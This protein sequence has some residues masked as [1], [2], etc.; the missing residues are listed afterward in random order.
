MNYNR[1]YG[2]ISIAEEQYWVSGWCEI[3]DTFNIRV[4]LL[5]L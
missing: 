5:K 2:M 4:K 1:R 3:G